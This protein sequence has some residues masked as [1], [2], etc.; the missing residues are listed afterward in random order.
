MKTSGTETGKTE[1]GKAEA[2]KTETGKAETSKTETG[3][4]ETSKTEADR[5]ETGKT[6]TRKTETGKEETGKTEIATPPT[7]RFAPSPSG[8]MHLGNL[9]CSLLAWL[10]AK[11]AGGRV[12]LRIEDLDPL[13][14]PRAFA[15]QIEEDL[16]WL[17]LVWDEGGSRGGPNGPYY[18]Q[19]RTA[20]YERA[21]EEL[22]ARGLTYPCFCSRAALHAAS[23]PHRA[24]GVPVYPGSCRGLSAAERAERA[25]H[26]PP[27]LRLRVPDETVAFTDGHLGPYAENLARDCGDFILRRSDGVHAY[28]LAVVL[29]D[30]AM[31]VTEVVRGADLLSS[32]PRQLYL[33]RLLGL[34][35][36][37]FF[38]LPLLMDAEGRRLSKRDGDVSLETLRQKYTPEEVVG[39]L[40]FLAGLQPAPAPR[41][42]ESLLSDFAWDKVPKEDI[43][44]PA[45]L[46]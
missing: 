24:D 37:R 2:D 45:G 27:A 26:R 13:R 34:P 14:C 1:T 15:D 11:S 35:A 29:D 6:E 4:T 41:T 43:C 42:A 9:F 7:G 44:I 20:L 30:A 19:E 31:G 17:G 5:A 22:T 8:R 39:R 33:Y 18:Q 38:H 28:Q 21:C 3:K 32:T 40:A 23:A 25:R 16:S 46:F 12:V 10:S 36:P